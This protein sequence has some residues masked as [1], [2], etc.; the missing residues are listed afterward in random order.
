[1]ATEKYLLDTNHLGMAVTPGS[2][3]FKRVDAAVKQGD[4]FGIC[5]PVLCELEVGIR[6]VN[7]PTAYRIAL[8][9]VFRSVRIWP[10]DSE[11]ARVYGEIYHELK[12]KGRARSQVDLLIASLAR[13][14]SLII[15]TTDRDFEALID[16]NTEN[17]S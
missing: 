13:Q 8:R 6:Q 1:M 17:W 16:I 9:N 12:T 10:L 4:K 2:K 14:M 15:L 3:V 11:T 5:I 7:N